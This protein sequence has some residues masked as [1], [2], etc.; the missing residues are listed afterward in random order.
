MRLLT[1]DGNAGNNL[2]ESAILSVINTLKMKIDPSLTC[3]FYIRVKAHDLLVEFLVDIRIF[4]SKLPQVVAGKNGS[5][6]LGGGMTLFVEN[7]FHDRIIFPA[8]YFRYFKSE[9]LR[10]QRKG[11]FMSL[12][13]KTT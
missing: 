7:I 9:S 13:K 5:F 11:R 6:F 4:L 3:G 8:F 10:R 12:S 1:I 2:L